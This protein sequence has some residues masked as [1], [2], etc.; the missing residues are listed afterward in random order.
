MHRE[1]KA[2]DFDLFEQRRRIDDGGHGGRG[3]IAH[4]RKGDV[5]QDEVEREINDTRTLGHLGEHGGKDRCHNDHHEQGVE[6]R[7]N[8]AQHASAI[9]EL[10]VF[11]DE[12]FEDE[13]ILLDII[14]CVGSNY[15]LGFGCHEHYSLYRLYDNG[16][17]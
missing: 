15:A 2:V 12:L 7:P 3:G 8:N 1:Y 4:K 9:L 13:D 6:Y 17:F 16:S 14:L 11:G 10:E 5:A